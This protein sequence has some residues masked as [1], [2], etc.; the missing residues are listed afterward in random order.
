MTLREILSSIGE[1]FIAMWQMVVKIAIT[2]DSIEIFGIR[3]SIVSAFAILGTIIRII[4]KALK[5]RR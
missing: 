4:Y 1:F 2:V 5:H 3:G